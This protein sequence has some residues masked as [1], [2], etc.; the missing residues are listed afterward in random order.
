MRS[1]GR[2]LGRRLEDGDV[3]LLIGD[4]GAGKTCFS[5][6]VGEGLGV[7]TTMGSP[8]FNIVFEYDSPK[9]ALYHFDLYRLDDPAQLDDIDFYDLSDS[10]TEGASLIE[11][12]DLFPDEMPDERLE[13]RIEARSD[14]S[15]K[16]T[17]HPFGARAQELAFSWSSACSENL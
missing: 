13:L 15:R 6:G 4:L 8:T 3:V 5:Q 10:S 14:G 1:L 17:V 9:T 12:A 11:W 7:A 2:A 16:I